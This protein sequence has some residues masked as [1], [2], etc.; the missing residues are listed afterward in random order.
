MTTKEKKPLG[1]ISLLNNTQKPV[2]ITDDFFNNYVFMKPVNW[3]RL[4]TLVN[5]FLEAYARIYN[6]QDGFHFVGENIKIKTQYEHYLQ[7]TAKQ[8]TQDIKIEELD[9]DNQTYIEIQNKA[10]TKPPISIRASNYSGLA[11]IKMKDQTQ[12]SQIWLLA[13]DDDVVLR[14]QA[15]SN[16]RMREDNTGDYYPRE[17]NIMFISLRRIAEDESICGKL[18]RYLLNG[19]IDGLD[20]ESSRELQEIIEMYKSEFNHFKNEEEVISSMTILDERYAEGREEGMEEGME[21]GKTYGILEAAQKML[22]AGFDIKA[23]SKALDIP[24]SQL[25]S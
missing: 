22:N 14:G 13:E 19:N 20:D 16:F 4:G 9:K 21:K 7:K 25:V 1:Y 23:V 18:A 5:I 6:R 8:P 3:P 10:S 24:E 12:N 11:V 17:I 2:Y 15:I